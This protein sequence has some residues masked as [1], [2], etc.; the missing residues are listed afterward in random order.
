MSQ[1]DPTSASLLCRALNRETGAWERLVMLYSPLV[2]HWCSQAGIPEPDVPDVSQDIFVAIASS[3]PRYQADR[4]GTKFRAW[5]RG[6]ARNKTRE[7]HKR[8]RTDRGIGGT[9]ALKRLEEIPDT[10]AGPD[11]SEGSDELGALYQ[12]VVDLLRDEFEERTWTSFWQVVV[13]GRAPSQ[14][15]EE[16]GITANA[17]RQARSRVIRRLREE[18]GELID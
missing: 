7:Y 17:V 6:I 12:R 11:L 15:A 18:M 13:E 5:M 3:L 9:D 4:P 2:R 8:T 14:V 10:D 1:N 16:M